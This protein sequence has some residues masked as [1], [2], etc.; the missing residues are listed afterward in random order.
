[1]STIAAGQFKQ[2]CLRL[3]DQVRET[4]DVVVI[5]K[6]GRPVAQLGPIPP[7]DLEDWSGIMRGKGRI[8]GDLT[9][10]TSEPEDWEA[11]SF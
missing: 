1:M 4:G 6:R 9:A 5:T 8:L 10:P 7:Q 11:E 3:L 2:T